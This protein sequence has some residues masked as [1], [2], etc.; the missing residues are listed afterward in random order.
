MG[1]KGIGLMGLENSSGTVARAVRAAF[2]GLAL[3]PVFAGTALY[4]A[5]ADAP[6]ETV[7]AGGEMLLTEDQVARFVASLAGMHRLGQTVALALPMGEFNP[8]DPLVP[9]AVLVEQ[10]ADPEPEIAAALATH[11]F[12]TLEEWLA[13][14][15]AV[16]PAYWAREAEATHLGLAV[17]LAPIVFAVQ[18]RSNPSAEEV[19]NLVDQL[20][21]D[22]ADPSVEPPPGNLRL[23][24][25]YRGRIGEALR[26]R[27]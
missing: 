12:A 8:D 14:G 4:P 11:G 21:A 6:G 22:M 25:K 2:V 3:C 1:P 24:G 27:P 18:G 5:R 16:M 10:A 7:L 23:V 9:Y 19:S 17:Q 15:A 20:K 26:V 13:V